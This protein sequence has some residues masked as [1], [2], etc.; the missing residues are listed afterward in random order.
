MLKTRDFYLTKVYDTKGKYLGVI[1]DL[2]ID[3]N[4]GKVKG[5]IISTFSLMK[6]R[7][8]AVI[9][10]ILSFEEVLIVRKLVHFEGL[11]FRDIK[12]MDIIN[13]SNIMKGVLEDLV[14]DKKDYSIHGFIVSSGIFDRMFKGKEI[15]LLKSCILCEDYILYI[16]EDG[17]R[18]KTLPHNLGGSFN[19]EKL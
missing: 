9:E 12:Y 17:V 15:I 10:D 16:G 1:N 3:F 2:S 4:E 19:V 8:Y 7:N 11:R 18:F 6:K 14:I 5:F 13:R